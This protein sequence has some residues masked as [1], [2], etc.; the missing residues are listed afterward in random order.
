[1][2]ATS[3]T[4]ESLR[5]HS[6]TKHIAVPPSGD[7]LRTRLRRSRGAEGSFR[8][9][10][11]QQLTVHPRSPDAF[12]KQYDECYPIAHRDSNDEHTA[13]PAKPSLAATSPVSFRNNSGSS[14]GGVATPLGRRRTS[15]PDRN[16]AYATG[17][18]IFI[19]PPTATPSTTIITPIARLMFRSRTDASSKTQTAPPRSICTVSY[20]GAAQCPRVRA[21]H[22]HTTLQYPLF[23]DKHITEVEAGHIP[24]PFNLDET[25]IVSRGI[26]VHRCSVLQSRR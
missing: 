24:G 15:R 7:L 26:S 6:S 11:C 22:H 5:S 16:S 20:N 13:D 17:T 9:E 10:P 25:H 21:A 4:R 18:S 19:S 2:L 23:V 8:N 1:M 3:L 12:S 14:S